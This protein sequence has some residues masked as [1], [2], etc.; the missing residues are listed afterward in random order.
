MYPALPNGSRF[1][2]GAELRGSQTE[3]YYA[4]LPGVHRICCGTRAASFKR[5]LG[6]ALRLLIF[7]VQRRK[8]PF[9]RSKQR[10]LGGIP[11][12]MV[13]MSVRSRN[14]NLATSEA[15][16]GK[17]IFESFERAVCVDKI[18][19]FPDKRCGV[20]SRTNPQIVSRI[21]SNERTVRREESLQ[22]QRLKRRTL[23]PAGGGTA[24]R[25]KHV[26]QCERRAK[27][28]AE[29]KKVFRV[30]SGRGDGEACGTCSAFE[31]VVV[32]VTSWPPIGSLQN[33][34][35]RHGPP[36]ACFRGAA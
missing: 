24:W 4:V 1:S 25:M 6:C 33:I 2:C 36:S 17:D 27:D 11:C 32:A 13:V 12:A 9:E 28:A 23:V 20:W 5:W 21:R 15:A 30:A 18:V 8:A 31:A 22:V 19:T 3:F 34:E 16:P 29:C 14:G 7:R 10:L 35:L 26:E